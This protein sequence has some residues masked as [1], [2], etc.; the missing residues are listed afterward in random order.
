M[1]KTNFL[2]TASVDGHVKFWKKNESGIEFVKHYRAHLGDIA[3]A[4]CSADG[5]RYATCA[6]DQKIK[7]FD[8]I[9]FDMINMISLSYFPSIIK[10]TYSG[11]S[12][13][14]TI[15]VVERDT[16]NITIYDS[17][18]SS[19]TEPI[20]KVSAAHAKTAVITSM[21][22]SNRLNIALTTDSQG[23]IEFWR[24]EAP[25]DY[26]E[27]YFEYKYKMKTD[28]YEL[29]KNKGAFCIQSNFSNDGKLFSIYGSDRM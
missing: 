7:I 9:N 24:T 15:A 27:E 19:G 22:F 12:N 2:I 11:G 3:Y 8:V 25:F 4:D 14:M 16:S 13:I 23:M 29:A 26:P 1:T 6:G 21:A 18:N 20:H 17:T 28:L 10:W 5:L